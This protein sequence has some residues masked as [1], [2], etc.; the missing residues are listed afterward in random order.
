[1]TD[2][3][4]SFSSLLVMYCF[5]SSDT[6]WYSVVLISRS[7]PRVTNKLDTGKGKSSKKFK[8]R[9]RHKFYSIRVKPRDTAFNHFSAIFSLNSYL[10]FNLFFFLNCFTLTKSERKSLILGTVIYL[11]SS[12]FP[13]WSIKQNIYKLYFPFYFFLFSGLSFSLINSSNR[14]VFQPSSI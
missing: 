2:P 14:Q 9:S 3:N 5:T 11:F 10:Y 4:S 12:L 13:S 6:V 8:I 7:L 1:M